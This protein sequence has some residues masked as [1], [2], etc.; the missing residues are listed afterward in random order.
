MRYPFLPWSEPQLKQRHKTRNAHT[1]K[2]QIWR[3]TCQAK[4]AHFKQHQPFHQPHLL[5]AVICPALDRFTLRKTKSRNSRNF[6][7]AVDNDQECGDYSGFWFLLG[8]PEVNSAFDE[9]VF[10]CTVA[11][12]VYCRDWRGWR[13]FGEGFERVWVFD[14]WVYWEL[15]FE[16]E[17]RSY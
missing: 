4:Q 8:E 5:P 1:K 2:H 15:E 7:V 6:V 10:A 12:S 13:N 16:S 14:Q 17:Q 9:A 11:D 3:K